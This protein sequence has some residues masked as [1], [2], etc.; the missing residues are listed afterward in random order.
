M[1]IVETSYH[2]KYNQKESYFTFALKENAIKQLEFF[3]KFQIGT[4]FTIVDLG[5]INDGT[6]VDE[7]KEFYNI[8]DKVTVYDFTKDKIWTVKQ[9]GYMCYN[10]Y[11]PYCEFITEKNEIDWCIPSINNINNIKFID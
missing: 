5:Q 10:C 3:N 1:R 11:R 9:I 4:K 6:F 2:R 8:L 7:V